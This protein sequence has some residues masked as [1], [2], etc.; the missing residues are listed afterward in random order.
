MELHVL[1]DN[2]T[3]PALLFF[4]LGILAARLKSDLEI[5]PNSS[6]FISLYLLFAIGFKGGQELAHSHFS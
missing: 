4:A 3:N 2:L 5:P 1:L 6:K